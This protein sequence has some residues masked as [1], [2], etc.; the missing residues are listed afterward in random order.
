MSAMQIALLLIGLGGCVLSG[1][2]AGSDRPLKGVAVWCL[3]VSLIA[4]AFWWW[5]LGAR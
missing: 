2:V 5:S 3:S 1:Y 4:T